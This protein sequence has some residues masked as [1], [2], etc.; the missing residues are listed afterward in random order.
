[1]FFLY[2]KI[3]LKAVIRTQ[4]YDLLRWSAAYFRCMATNVPPPVKVRLE[5]DQRY[6]D[7][8]R[9]YLRVLLEQ[10]G[11]GFFI[12]QKVLQDRWIN[13]SLPEASFD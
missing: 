1:M 9:G 8:T 5:R 6:G 13:L 11:K 10:V 4:P 2:I 3:L 12:N 7:L